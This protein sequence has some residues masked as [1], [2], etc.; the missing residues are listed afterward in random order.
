MRG[1]RRLA[2]LPLKTEQFF[3]LV[4]AAKAVKVA[5]SLEEFLTALDLEEH[6]AQFVSQG[7][8]R[9]SDLR[10]IENEQDLQALRA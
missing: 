3:F 10:L 7:I 1:G 6:Y 2:I 4:Q 5:S 8:K 9:V